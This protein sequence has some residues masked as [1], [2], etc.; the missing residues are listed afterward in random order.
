MQLP[1]GSQPPSSEGSI[2]DY[3]EE[4]LIEENAKKWSKFILDLNGDAVKTNGKTNGFA[5]QNGKSNGFVH[6]NDQTNGFVATLKSEDEL[7][8]TPISPPYIVAPS[9][10]ARWPQNGG[11]NGSALYPTAFHL[12]SHK[13]LDQA[14]H[15]LEA[16]SDESPPYLPAN[17]N[18][19]E[20][21]V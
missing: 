7:T 21:S 5:H 17:K 11:L 4:S 10:E 13:Q 20:K 3:T 16:E 19:V 15:I 9:F 1:R 12:T 14:D 6:H 2:I 18:F 8:P